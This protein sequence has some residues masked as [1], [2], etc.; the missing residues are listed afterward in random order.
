V[1]VPSESRVLTE[2]EL[3]QSTPTFLVD[4]RVAGSWKFEKGRVK[5]RPFEKLDPAAKRELAAEGDRLAELH[6]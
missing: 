3:N 6:A 5:L 1:I 2:R 4:G